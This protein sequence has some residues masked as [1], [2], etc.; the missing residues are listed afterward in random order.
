MIVDPSEMI[1]IQ[2]V[3]QEERYEGEAVYYGTDDGVAEC[4][5][6]QQGRRREE[7]SHVR[8]A[9][10]VLD[11]VHR[12]RGRTKQKDFDIVLNQRHGLKE[13]SGST[14]Q[15]L[16]HDETRTRNKHHAQ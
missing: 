8:R 16:K 2:H 11:T 14:Q 10:G 12:A 3:K 15:S 13:A 7:C 6:N 9:R 4:D 5:D 1:F